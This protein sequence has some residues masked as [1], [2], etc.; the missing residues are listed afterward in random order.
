MAAYLSSSRYTSS[1]F[2]SGTSSIPIS[3]RKKSYSPRYYNYVAKE[4]DSFE[5]IASLLFGDPMRWWEIADLNTH[6]PFPDVIE[7][8]KTLRIPTK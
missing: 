5:L 6:V 8:G 7:A 3:V 2:D 1:S 4:G